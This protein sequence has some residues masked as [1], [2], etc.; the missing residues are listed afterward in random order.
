M[1]REDRT[2]VA[3]RPRCD[4]PRVMRLVLLFL[5]T[6]L[7]WVEIDR[8]WGT[9]RKVLIAVL[10]LATALAFVRQP[11]ARRLALLLPPLLCLA[12]LAEYALWPSPPDASRALV[13]VALVAV[14]AR[15][16]LS[17]ELLPSPPWRR[18]L[19]GACLSIAALAL[20][21]LGGEWLHERGRPRDP[22]NI[23]S[24]D[25]QG[26][27]SIYRRDPVLWVKL[28]PGF[29]GHFVHPQYDGQLVTV[30][31]EGYRG[32]DWPAE[33]DPDAT[34]VLLL[35]DSMSFG[36]GAED[37]ETIAVHLEAGLAAAIPGRRFRVYNACVPGYGPRHW[38]V[39]VESLRARLRPRLC[40]ATFY[41]GND[42]I[43]CRYQFVRSREAG[44]HAERLPTETARVGESFRRPDVFAYLGG[45][46]IPAMWT[47]VYWV[48]YSGLFRD[49]DQLAA[50]G[51]DRWGWNSLTFSY[52]DDLLRAMRREPDLDIEEEFGLAE[53]AYARMDE[54]CRE[55][56]ST[57]AIYRVPGV[58]Q[59]EPTTYRRL[60]AELD[61]DAAEF[62][63]QLPGSRLIAW[64]RSSG[65]PALDL[66]PRLEV[67]ER[68]HCLAFYPEGHP[69]PSGNQRIAEEIIE[70]IRTDPRLA[71]A[72]S[73]PGPGGDRER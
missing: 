11:I 32:P 51:L 72:V 31:S 6:T 22:Y 59:C 62:D 52:S 28:R 64:A 46:E 5:V 15:V 65:I 66:L 18:G 9:R 54:L 8:T 60:M 41:D 44:V 3:F 35:G 19:G 33:A 24:E 25:P 13:I 50:R 69:N 73:A 37:D 43:D 48:R 39:Q 61:L 67:G 2:L 17:K 1:T 29:R 38:L 55:Q 27:R 16:A 71:A 10:L 30:N 70:W 45:T 47:R 63:R 4:N 23:V 34:N 7:V 42:L 20:A 40:L 21:F 53:G 12:M 57:F 58:V 49:L 68:E 26:P 56:G 36:L 14:A